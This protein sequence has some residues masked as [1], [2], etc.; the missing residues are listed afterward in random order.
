MTSS[1]PSEGRSSGPSIAR[2]TA[3]SSMPSIVPTAAPSSSPTAA[4][5]AS[6]SLS[7]SGVPSLV[8]SQAPADMPSTLPSIYHTELSSEAPSRAS[9]RSNTKGPV[10]QP[11]TAAPSTTKSIIP[12][13]AAKNFTFKPSVAPTSTSIGSLSDRP[14]NAGGDWDLASST[15][16]IYTAAQSIE[17]CPQAYD[18]GSVAGY[19]EGSTVETDGVR[20]R[21]NPYPYAIY[22]KS[23]EYRPLSK[24]T[25]NWRDA[26]QE[27]G[28]CLIATEAVSSLRGFPRSSAELAKLISRNFV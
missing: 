8:P 5:S 15:P 24:Q 12:E 17:E 11:I 13:I 14:S 25:D 2:S 1:M 27:L 28:P 6:P 20:Y 3:P 19:V 7:G 23:P 10:S 22:C 18:H 21:C 16:T 4:G 9:I 26:W